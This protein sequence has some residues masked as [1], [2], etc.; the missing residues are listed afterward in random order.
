M[1]GGILATIVNH[2]RKQFLQITLTAFGILAVLVAVQK[3]IFL[4]LMLVDFPTRM[5]RG[6]QDI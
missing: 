3:V 2:R 5:M 1:D 6:K 4:L